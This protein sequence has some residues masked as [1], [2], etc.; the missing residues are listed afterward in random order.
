M[1]A[2]TETRKPTAVQAR[3]PHPVEWLIGGISAVLVVALLSYLA[4]LGM[5]A[6][7]RP[8][9]FAVTVEEIE[10]VGE[11]FHINVAVTN[12]GDSTAAGVIVRARLGERGELVETGEIEFDYLPAG[13]TR[14]GAFVFTN[15]P[16]SRDLELSVLGYTEP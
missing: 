3:T 14:R 15:D 2:K 4:Y 8:P 13:S 9:E 1:A 16:V 12:P 10:K 5:A 11:R 6:D 7:D